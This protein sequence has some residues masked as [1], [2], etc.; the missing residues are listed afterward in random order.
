M[1]YAFDNAEPAKQ[2]VARRLMR[3]HPD[4]VISTQVLLEFYSVV[5][6]TISPSLPTTSP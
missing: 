5:T 1:V 3:D 2:A 6:R 4:A